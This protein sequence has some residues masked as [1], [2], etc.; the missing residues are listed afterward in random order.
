MSETRAASGRSGLTIKQLTLNDSLAGEYRS[1]R[2]Q[3][4]PDCAED[5]EREIVEILADVDRWAVFVALQNDSRVDGFAEAHLR[6]YA[7][8]AVSQPVGFIEGW[9][10]VPEMR[11]RGVG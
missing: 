5:C 2:I 3:V 8:S 1:L 9:F 6:E 4:W 11:K 10:V 7:E